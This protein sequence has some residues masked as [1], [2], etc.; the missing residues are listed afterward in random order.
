MD[1]ITQIEAF[2][3]VVEEGGFTKVA[4]KMGV[5]KASVS[6][7]IKALEVRLGVTLLERN[8]SA[9]IA[10]TEEG[11]RY[12]EESRRLLS[13]FYNMERSVHWKDLGC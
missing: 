5:S 3:A 1:R 7:W 4:A 6:K 8:T 2:V 9:K 11:K 10:I 12:Y 13:V